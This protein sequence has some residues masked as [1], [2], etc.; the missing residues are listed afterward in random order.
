MR[1][2]FFP[3]WGQFYNEQ[4]LKSVIVFS[5]VTF[6]VVQAVR[7]NR[8]AA[9]APAGSA[10]RASYIDKRNLQFWFIGATTLLSMVDAYVDALL[11]DFD[12]G[13]Q[14]QLRTGTL[15]KTPGRTHVSNSI[16]VTLRVVF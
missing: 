7:F 5:G 14:L 16:G 13:P 15:P 11:Y 3:G 8:K 12:A 1:S 2:L 10:Q 4:Y 6:F 9:D